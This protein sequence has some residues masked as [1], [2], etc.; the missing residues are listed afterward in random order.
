MNKGREGEKQAAAWLEENSRMEILVR[1]FRSRYG[2]I[3]IIAVEG[4]TIVFIEVKTWSS[5]GLE[6]LQY[7]INPGKQ[8]RIIKT[9]KFFLFE[10]RKYS[11]MAVRFDVIFV[12]GKQL[13]AGFNGYPVTHLASA[14]TERVL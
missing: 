7:S 4:E 1:N 12:N 6:E 2:E 11:R 13:P 10:N 14:F 3:D 5:Y 9:A 8:R